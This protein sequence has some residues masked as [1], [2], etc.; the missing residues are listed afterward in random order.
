MLLCVL[1]PLFSFLGMEA[2]SFAPAE[3]QTLDDAAAEILLESVK[4]QLRAAAEVTVKEFT[5]LPFEMEISAHITA[6][7][8]IDIQQV[9][10]TFL[11]DFGQREALAA[12]LEEA[13]G[14]APSVEI[15]E[16]E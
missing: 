16:G 9:R 15:R 14:F 13:F 12:A 6:D 11:E 7:Y 3:E 10:L 8:G 2:P 4:R 1:L 5:D